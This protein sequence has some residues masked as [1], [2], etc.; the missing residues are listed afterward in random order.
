MTLSEKPEK[1]VILMYDKESKRRKR[2]DV[3]ESED[4]AAYLMAEYQLAFGNGSEITYQIAHPQ[5]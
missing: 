1:Y 5:S 4:S 3:A 2:V